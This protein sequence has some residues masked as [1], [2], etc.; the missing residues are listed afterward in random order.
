MALSFF[1]AYF[2]FALLSLAKNRHFQ[3]VWP[4]KKLTI[5]LERELRISG[6]LLLLISTTHL[7]QAPKISIGLTDVIGIWTFAALIVVLQL[8]YLPRSVAGIGII[9][10]LLPRSK[11]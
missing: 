4:H 11:N 1:I 7:I 8:T 6:W 10:Q 5:T 9:T 3:Q 2:G